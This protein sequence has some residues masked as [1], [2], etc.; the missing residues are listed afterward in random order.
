MEYSIE[1]KYEKLLKARYFLAV[2]RK[3]LRERIEEAYSQFRILKENEFEAEGKVIRSKIE[4]LL[5]KNK[6]EVGYIIP[7]NIR[8]MRLAR[9]EEIAALILE[10]YDIVAN[11]YATKKARSKERT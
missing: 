2:S 9:A 11:E 8:H 1:Y 4:H 10:L 3:S 6:A 5:T 7:H